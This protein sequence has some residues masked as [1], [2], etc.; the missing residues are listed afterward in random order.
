MKLF[1]SYI[2]HFHACT[3][4]LTSLYKNIFTPAVTGHTLVFVRQLF[5]LSF[6]CFIMFSAAR[7]QSVGKRTDS[8][9]KDIK[10]LQ[11]GDSISDELWHMP[12]QVVNHP[13]GK[14]TITLNDYRDKEFII[15]D[16]WA[17]WCAPCIKE[18]PHLLALEGSINC[19]VIPLSDEPK[20]K[21]DKFLANDLAFQTS[22][23]YIYKRGSA[24]DRSFERNSIP[25]TVIIY[26]GK[27]KS[28]TLPHLISTQNLRDVVAG[29]SE[30]LIPKIELRH[31]KEDLLALASLDT[32]RKKSTGF[33]IFLQGM[34][35]VV[36]GV[37]WEPESPT[38]GSRLQI[39]NYPLISIIAL[40]TGQGKIFL[41]NPNKIVVEGLHE[42]RQIE[43]AEWDLLKTVKL[44]YESDYP[45]T[46]SYS[47]AISDL[48]NNLASYRNIYCRIEKIPSKVVRFVKDRE[49]VQ[50]ETEFRYSIREIAFV[51]N[52]IP[53]RLS[54]VFQ[55]HQSDK[56]VYLP[57]E[58]SK[59][60]PGILEESLLEQGWSKKIEDICEEQ[61]V[62]TLN[63]II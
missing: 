23:F 42:I 19:K 38:G 58:L 57:E 10:P 34:D 31:S 28:F 13:D 40:A 56:L 25:H 4:K 62:V 27:V 48:K 3:Q 61:L 2:G 51:L 12:L 5:L 39:A 7:A 6:F 26:Q 17:T 49:T 37:L 59:T 20:I 47:D 45:H 18:L 9:L 43:T 32:N 60:T 53:G 36:P 16:F 24:I 30:T 33:S 63:G 54:V 44:S 46:R 50:A 52:Q 14:D 21:I 41:R 11:I 22:K 15:L 1:Y 35:G 8:G 55:E 29:T